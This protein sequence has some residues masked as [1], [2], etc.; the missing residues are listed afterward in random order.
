MGSYRLSSNAT[1]LLSG[2]ASGELRLHL[3]RHPPA[4]SGGSQGGWEDA[5]DEWE[6]AAA[7]DTGVG[8]PL[9]LSLIESLPP[10]ALLCGCGG[11]TAPG[12][13]AAAGS[14]AGAAGGAADAASAAAAKSQARCPPIAAIHGSG[15]GGS[16]ASTAVVT[17]AAGAL[18]VL[19]HGGPGNA[20]GELAAMVDFLPPCLLLQPRQL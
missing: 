4:P 19:K 15:R 10:E 16:V 7:A 12:T 9:R 1:V 11:G 8:A 20:G 14:E 18:A 2:H 17:D 13:C 3:L 6:T 5:E